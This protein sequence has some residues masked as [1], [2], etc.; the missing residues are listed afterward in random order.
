MGFLLSIAAVLMLAAGFFHPSEQIKFN[1]EPNSKE[2]KRIASL[3][4][5]DNLCI[6]NTGASEDLCVLPGI[7]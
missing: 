3:P 7:G 5:L 6:F 4:H 1:F 2:I